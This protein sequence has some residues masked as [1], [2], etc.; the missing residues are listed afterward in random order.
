[1]DK[2]LA[3]QTKKKDTEAQ[4]PKEGMKQ[5]C[6][7]PTLPTSKG[8]KGNTLDISTYKSDIC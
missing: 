8:Q 7:L 3:R 4:I 6:S 5:R 1:M 2:S